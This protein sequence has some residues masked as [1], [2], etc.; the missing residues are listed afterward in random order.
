MKYLVVFVL[1][2]FLG[3][4]QNRAS[5][6]DK[7]LGKWVR[8]EKMHPIRYYVTTYDISENGESYKV[9]V[10]IDCHAC[11]KIPAV[12]YVFSGSYNQEKD[13]FELKREAFP[14]VLMIDDKTNRMIS[15]RKPEFQFTKQY[16]GK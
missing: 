12:K 15:D 7:F 11:E 5:K 13:V 6:A 1:F 16:S 10:T 3:S 4:C 8:E 2:V 14:E 9:N